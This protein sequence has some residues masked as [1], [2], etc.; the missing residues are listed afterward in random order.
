M[1]NL[2]R[3]NDIRQ[4]F[5]DALADGIYTTDKT[6]VKTLE[7]C[8]TSFFA[9]E[10]AI[11]GEVNRAYV[12]AELAWYDSKSLN[13]NDIPGGPPKIWKQVATQ[14]GW[15]NSNYGWCIYSDYN[16]KQYNAARNELIAN[17]NSRR[18]VMIYTRPTMH[19]DYCEDG[20]SDFMCTNVVQY[21]IRGNKLHAIVQ[22]RSNDV[23]FGY[24]NDRAWQFEVQNRLLKDI[25]ELADETYQLGDLIWH[26]GSLHVYERHFP[27]IDIV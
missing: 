12:K 1:I 4:H 16:H 8:G 21:L 22:M 26:V 14:D 2:P 11:F 27:L 10:E 5:K 17:R 20:C 24:K 3:V 15:I 6:G 23:I 18:A 19:E 7:L 25:N 13:V 9:D